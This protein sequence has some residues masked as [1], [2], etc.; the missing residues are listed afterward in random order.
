[1]GAVLDHR[2]AVITITIG[3]S[4][5]VWACGAV[6][7]AQSSVEPTP[8]ADAAAPYD[9]DSDEALFL[10]VSING[11]S[12]GLVGE[13]AM[14]PDARRMMAQRDALEGIGIAAPRALGQT[15]Y[16]D[17]IPGL[18]FVYDAP[19]QVIHI[20]AQGLTLI[21]VEISAVPKPDLPDAQTGFGVVLNYRVTTNL[22]RNVFEDGFQP[23]HA[24]ATLDLRTFTPIGVLTTTGTVSSGL[25]SFGSAEFRRLET[26]FTVSSQDRMLT[27]TAGDFTTSGPSW[28][29]PVRL[30]GLQIR[31]DF[32]LREDV[33]TSPLLSFSGSPKVPSSI[34]VYVDNIRAYSGAVGAGPFNLSNVPMI[35]SGGEATFVL[36]DAGGN[37]TTS[38][39]PFF[40]TQNLLAKGMLDFSIEAGRP[41]L[42]QGARYSSYGQDTA[43]AV[44]LRYG[45]SSKLTVEGHA[46]YLQN[47]K[48][49]GF[50]VH[51]VLFN[52]A[53]VTVAGGKSSDG[54]ATG[55]FLFTALRTEVG[56]VGISFSSRRTFGDF[57]DL[58]GIKTL[59]VQDG[60]IL[61][62]SVPNW[63]SAA[64]IDALALSFPVLADGGRFGINL[65]NSERTGLRNT[66]LSASY[67]RP[68]PGLGSFRINGFKD[69]TGDGGL[70]LGVGVSI[71]LGGARHASAGLQRDRNG[72]TDLVASLSKS[73][74]RTAGSYGY[75]VNLSRQNRVVGATYQTRY[76]RAD[77]L[78]RDSVQGTS[79]SATL[80]G[81]VVLAGRG[82]FATNRI[83]DGFAVVAV[84]SPDVAVSL[85]NREVARTGVFGRALVPDLRSYRV[86][87]ISIN[88]LDLP[89]DASVE[90]TAMNVVVARRSGV[91]VDFGGK[92]EAAALVV[93]SDTAGAFVPPGSQV[94]LRGSSDS[95][96]VGYDGE[97]WI[98]GLGPSN[99]ITA[100]TENADCS[101]AFAYAQRSDEQVYIDGVTCR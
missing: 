46:E 48:M 99:H 41:R 2:A 74:A 27:M 12:I 10:L 30:G 83:H 65:I 60:Q 31:R 43:A 19:S 75:R 100:Q 16:L 4:L 24:F 64:A 34:E 14:S 1:M 79:A 98:T 33:V 85:N 80:D 86:N 20:T 29:R 21:P 47:L 3:F 52:R 78:L 15:V 13:F 76:G 5:G 36:R 26:S 67:S 96:I 54:P 35:T 18:R 39:V 63:G 77:V 9:P 8:I 73:A 89:I 56:D 11:R 68:L 84:G 87:R 72:R 55:S 82:I 97:V 28:V 92:P 93:L 6:A 81:A 32:S 38:V 58:A 53:E 90:A 95:F 45:V 62:L 69:F 70:G 88:P 7:I 17:Q 66:I 57:R 49:A 59:Q 50:G 71:P 22:G 40:A 101:A 94:Q 61:P 37:E 42:S 91:S 44:S 51:A 23:E 25:S